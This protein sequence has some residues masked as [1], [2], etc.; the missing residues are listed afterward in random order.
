M[1]TFVLGDIHGCFDTLQALLRQIQ[2]DRR[3]DR[4]WLVGDLVN[5]GPE[6]LAVLRWA[7]DLGDRVTVVLGNHDLH[8][9]GR[10]W[11]V[12]VV[13]RRDALAEVL[14]ARDR[15]DLL[16]WLR[17]RPL[18]HRQDG[19]VMVHAGL[20][21]AWDMDKAE[22]L[23]RETERW[24]RGD[25]APRLV[26]TMGRK[27]AERWKG[28]M[29]DWDRVRVALAAFA[30]LRTIQPDGRMCADFSGPPAEAPKGC[31]PWFAVPGRRSAGTPIVF[32]HWAALDLWRGDGVTGLD[33]GCAWGRSLTAL[34]LDDRK[35]FQEPAVEEPSE[36]I[37]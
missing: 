8:L 34:R 14:A 15:D 19:L 9:L 18:L 3:T 29:S 30:K 35:I 1:A 21:P 22:R 23:A 20:L 25:D 13:K 28:G 36:S 10:A 2:F 26:E 4:L 31:L 7:V 24:L 32:G 17:T 27:V 5:R 11:G 12:A 6:S 37:R 33:T 16:H